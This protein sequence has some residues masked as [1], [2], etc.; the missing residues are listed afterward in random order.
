MFWDN[1]IKARALF[2]HLWSRLYIYIQGNHVNDQTGIPDGLMANCDD[3]LTTN[4][5]Y[6]REV[7][8]SLNVIGRES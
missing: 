6:A 1:H 4:K 5:T 2:P 8:Y 7:Y 3:N